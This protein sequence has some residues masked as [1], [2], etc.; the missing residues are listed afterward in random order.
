MCRNVNRFHVALLTGKKVKKTLDMDI[1]SCY[2]EENRVK[3][4]PKWQDTILSTPL[5][6]N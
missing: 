6:S 3:E 4:V 1:M 5:D 2:N